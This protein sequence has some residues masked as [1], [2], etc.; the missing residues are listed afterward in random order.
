MNE[1][2]IDIKLVTSWPENEIVNLYKSAGW[3]KENYD[4]SKIEDM[5][6]GSF[7]FAVAFI[8]KSDKA[9]GMGRVLSDGVSDAYI[10]D[11]VVLPEFQDA[12]IGKKI[13]KKL[14]DFCLL[15]NII[16]IGLI[17][18]P[19]Q[20]GFYSNIG[21]NILKDYTPMKYNKDD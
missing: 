4:S 14:L 15:K 6:N 2:I 21:F 16:W 17:A 7:A 18:E 1:Q 3:W 5:I 19:K 10:Q 8:K 13:V 20:S 11:L 9:V 12:G